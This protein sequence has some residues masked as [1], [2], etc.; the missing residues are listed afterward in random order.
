MKQPRK[1]ASNLIRHI[2]YKDEYNSTCSMRVRAVGGNGWEWLDVWV[3]ETACGQGCVGRVAG[4]VVRDVCVGW[5]GLSGQCISMN[6]G[7]LACFM[8][9]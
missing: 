6:S 5:V 9:W 8:S 7:A 3:G 2:W 4:W 1:Q